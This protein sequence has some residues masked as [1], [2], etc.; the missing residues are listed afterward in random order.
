MIARGAVKFD[1]DNDGDLDILI[2]NVSVVDNNSTTVKLYKNNASQS[3]NW[4]KLSL[5]NINNKPIYNSLIRLYTNGTIYTEEIQGGSSHA[6]KNSSITHVGLGTTNRVDSLTIQWPDGNLETL[7]NLSTNQHFRYIRSTSTLEIVGCTDPNSLNYHPTATYN[8]GCIENPVA[9]LHNSLNVLPIELYYNGGKLHFRAEKSS[10]TQHYNI[11]IFTISGKE[12]F[13]QNRIE[14]SSA[15]DFENQ[16]NGLYVYAIN[17]W[18]YSKV[19]SG[20]FVKP[21][22]NE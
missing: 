2:S 7:Y 14:L 22:I 6:S 17:S 20:K 11:Q 1:Y 18:D 10:E 16:P 15:I 9:S 4:L 3:N 21:V 8:S 12:I 13:S 19:Y 5:E